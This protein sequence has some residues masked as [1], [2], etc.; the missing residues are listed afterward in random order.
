MVGVEFLQICQKKEEPKH[1]AA[2]SDIKLTKPKV[3]L[4]EFSS[5]EFSMEDSSDIEPENELS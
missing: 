1:L 2:I 3:V 4:E 5:S